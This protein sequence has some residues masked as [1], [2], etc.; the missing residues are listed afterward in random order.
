MLYHIQSGI[1]RII[2]LHSRPSSPYKIRYEIR[3][4]C[5]QSDGTTTSHLGGLERGLRAAEPAEH[6]LQQLGRPRVHLRRAPPRLSVAV[7]AC[8]PAEVD[9]SSSGKPH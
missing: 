5:C 1:G 7:P 8:Q 2:T 6:P 3:H 9:G 4:P